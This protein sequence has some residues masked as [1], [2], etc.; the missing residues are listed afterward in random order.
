MPG[1]GIALTPEQA[2]C[3]ERAL[4]SVPPPDKPD[5][6]SV[7]AAAE[8]GWKLRRALYAV[9]AAAIAILSGALALVVRNGGR[10]AARA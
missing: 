9:V 5:L 8:R 4:A 3:S 6:D 2:S 10:Q 1:A 7:G